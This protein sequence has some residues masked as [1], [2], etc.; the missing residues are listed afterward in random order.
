MK[1]RDFL[2]RFATAA[3]ASL[4]GAA[5]AEGVVQHPQGRRHGA[6]R[7]VPDRFTRLGI[8]SWSFHDFFLSTRD[9]D[10]TLPETRIVLMDFPE[11]IA[12]RYKVHNLEFV[13][14]HF[15]SLEP[16]YIEELKGKLLRAR[17]RLINIPVD[18]PGLAQGGGLS[19]PDPQVRIVAVVAS[20]KWI[21][22]AKALGGR[23][24]RCD[25]GKLNPDDLSP[26]I[27][28]YKELA[29]YGRS[30]GVAVL[31]EN[32]GGVG[33]EHPDELLRIFQAVGGS[34]IGAL[35][36]FGNFPDQATRERG[37]PLLFPYA[38]TVCH[39]K[40]LEFDASGNETKFDFAKC[41]EIAKHAGFKGV[42]SI[43]YEGS[44]DPY[45]GVQKV[46]DELTRYL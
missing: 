10:S 43:E 8:S 9:Q 15:A 24:V 39:A 5:A 23:S 3:G 44:G 45:D 29:A 21:D 32:H 7:R 37:L 30:K 18:I 33:S 14:P 16:L 20:K 13:A 26:T 25:P 34:F 31:I 41:M 6:R 19:D 11:M 27:E 46:V 4:L 2:T 12:D 35:P 38:R 1:R 36:D 42:Y 17:S 22:I 40:G 28:S